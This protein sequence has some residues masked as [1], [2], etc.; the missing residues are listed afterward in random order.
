MP[1]PCFITWLEREVGYGPA[2]RSADVLLIMSGALFLRSG[3]ICPNLSL[4]RK[5]LPRTGTTR[6]KRTLGVR[7]LT[8]EAYVSCWSGF[9]LQGI[10]RFEL[11][12]L[13]NISNRLFMLVITSI[14]IVLNGLMIIIGFKVMLG[15][16]YLFATL[17]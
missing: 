9:P 14:I 5:R 17:A 3:G 2:D 6:R 12:R 10:H 15:Y 13:S 11:P 4:S 8:W 7:G 16:N 1:P